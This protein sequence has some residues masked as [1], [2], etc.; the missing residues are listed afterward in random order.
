MGQ[1][2]VRLGFY[3]VDY[4]LDSV[5]GWFQVGEIGG[6][7]LQKGFRPV[8]KE[9][10]L[11]DLRNIRGKIPDDLIGEYVRNGPNPKYIPKGQFPSSPR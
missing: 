5:Q 6:R 1:A 7:Y 3:P 4:L 9:V 2:L 10:F 11:S 8:D